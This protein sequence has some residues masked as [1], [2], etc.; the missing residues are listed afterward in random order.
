MQINLHML[1]P[2]KNRTSL[3]LFFQTYSFVKE[4]CLPAFGGKLKRHS[5]YGK[6]LGKYI[7]AHSQCQAQKKLIFI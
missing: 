5:T 3:H 1:L 2:N 4:W 6:T 7:S